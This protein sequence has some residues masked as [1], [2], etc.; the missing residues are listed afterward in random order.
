MK[1]FVGADREQRMLTAY[2]LEDWLPER[3]LA[4]FVIDIVDKLNFKGI[5]KRY[6]GVGSTPYDPKMLLGLL[7]YGY[8]TGNG[9]L[10]VCSMDLSSNLDSRPVACQFRQSLF[11]YMQS[12]KFDPKDEL[13]F[14]AVNQLF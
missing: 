5:Y 7:F 10:I 11:R 13:S 1:K 12:E 4:R 14:D 8:S 6:R 2:D 3:H 9:K